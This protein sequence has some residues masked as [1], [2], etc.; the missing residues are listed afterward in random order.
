MKKNIFILSNRCPLSDAR[1]I[2]QAFVLKKN[3][4]NVFLFASKKNGNEKIKFK[5]IEINYFDKKSLLNLQLKNIYSF[6]Q[7]FPQTYELI[8]K[9]YVILL[10]DKKIKS[11]NNLV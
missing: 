11:I 7:I 8:K 3:K 6:K 5:D 2:K 4:F 10:S 1:V 9:Y